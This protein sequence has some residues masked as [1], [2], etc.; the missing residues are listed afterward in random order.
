M[1]EDVKQI[2]L[3]Q[4]D[5]LYT[6]NLRWLAIRYPHIYE[7]LSEK[8]VTFDALEFDDSGD[9]INI[10][11][12]DKKLYPQ[13]LHTHI[14]A[15]MD[16]KEAVSRKSTPMNEFYS[17][18]YCFGLSYAERMF[19]TNNLISRQNIIG[20]QYIKHFFD[21]GLLDY[22]MMVNHKHHPHFN[23]SAFLVC[24]GLGLGHHIDLLFEKYQFANLVIFEKNY[25]FIQYAA[26][27]HDFSVW[28]EKC[29]N[30]SGKLIIL[31]SAKMKTQNLD[32]EFA[33]SIY[34]SIYYPLFDNNLFFTHIDDI[35]YREFDVDFNKT[36]VSLRFGRGFL[37]DEAQMH[38]NSMLNIFRTLKTKRLQNDKI[39][40]KKLVDYQKLP[41]LLVANGPS[42]DESI[43]IIKQKAAQGY[44]IM[45]CGTTLVTLLEYD[46]FPD[47]FINSENT[48]VDYWLLEKFTRK[49][50]DDARWKN[51]IFIGFQTTSP[52]LVRLFERVIYVLRSH[53]TNAIDTA[54][55]VFGAE[56]AKKGKW[57]I[58]FVTPN[59]VNIALGITLPLGFQ[60]IYCLGMDL[61]TRFGIGHSKKS[62]YQQYKIDDFKLGLT[63]KR[64]YQMDEMIYRLLRLK[65]PDFTD[66][67]MRA[68]FGGSAV[69]NFILDHTSLGIEHLVNRIEMVHID[70][71]QLYNCSDGRY[72]DHLTPLF[73]H[74]IPD[75]PENLQN[76]DK[77]QEKAKLFDNQYNIDI[78]ET[79]Q[80]EIKMRIAHNC[81]VLHAQL[82]EIQ[83]IITNYRTFGI[84]EYE[85]FE[86]FVSQ[87]M[88]VFSQNNVKNKELD[89]TNS[90]V[91]TLLVGTIIIY[92]HHIYKIF[93]YIDK[94]NYMMFMDSMLT[95]LEDLLTQNYQYTEFI[96]NR[97]LDNL[98]KYDFLQAQ[99]SPISINDD[100][101]FQNSVHHLY[102]T[103][104]KLD[105][106]YPGGLHERKVL[107]FVMGQ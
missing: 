43:D 20:T 34:S 75:L 28:E 95:D 107:P 9:V 56:E 7:I 52:T 86:K 41:L 22:D 19:F 48:F 11:E 38:H 25:D 88:M 39:L 65:S 73:P 83:S 55:T 81:D 96:F 97:S 90:E 17:P 71:Y 91:N 54:F 94:K 64:G 49:Y 63:C 61:G 31:D 15:Q 85:D 8:K 68:N 4:A 58:D 92:L 82:N 35:N 18:E 78:G 59:V 100:R 69:S 21:D 30:K 104:K 98:E 42:L 24:F 51:I 10:F 70:R 47:I 84:E 27:F 74:L 14:A 46:I 29:E 44:M 101:Y 93:M 105:V 89:L 79:E 13:D 1:A 32:R 45:A 57:V 77:E 76:L 106:S 37:E 72:I 36:S 5:Q 33:S 66:A 2:K 62:F 67:K 60:N 99:E 6:K 23:G 103:R 102:I 12:Q 16:D 80:Q 26:H 40:T 53:S 50:R 87:I 3:I